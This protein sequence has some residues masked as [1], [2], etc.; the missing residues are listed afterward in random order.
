MNNGIEKLIIF[1]FFLE[2]LTR[3]AQSKLRPRAASNSR[4]IGESLHFTAKK[5]KK[6]H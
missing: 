5:K 3:E 1:F 2:K 4:I 6:K